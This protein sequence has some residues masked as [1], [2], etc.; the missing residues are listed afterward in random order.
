MAPDSFIHRSQTG[1]LGGT[2]PLRASAGRG[3]GPLT[4]ADE[5][6]ARPPATPEPPPAVA[7]A[8]ATTADLSPAAAFANDLR[9]L[10]LALS[11]LP[12]GTEALEAATAVGLLKPDDPDA[13]SLLKSLLRLAGTPATVANVPGNSLAVDVLR[14]IA[15][16]ESIHQ[17]KGTFTCT[18]ATAQGILAARDPAEYARLVTD[19]AVDGKA[20]TKG[21]DTII[22]DLRGFGT[23]EGRSGTSDL[24]QE[25]FM[26]FGRAGAAESSQGGVFGFA[27]GA[28]NAF[29]GG[30]FGSGS[31]ATAPKAAQSGQPLPPPPPKKPPGRMGSTEAG[32]EKDGLTPAQFSRLMT[33]LTGEASVPLEI[34]ATTDRNALL[35]LIQ[36]SLDRDGP[37]PV[38]VSAED[39][40]THQPTFHAIQLTSFDGQSIFY[41]DPGTG[42][43]GSM[44]LG[45]FFDSLRMLNVPYDTLERVSK[46]GGLGLGSVANVAPRSS[47][48]PREAAWTAKKRFALTLEP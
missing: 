27:N 30:V 42:S 46:D 44:P 16:P 32:A 31:R 2:G 14:D 38:G 33:S 7:K 10:G 47:Q 1:R 13:R 29:T 37:I 34:D 24:L 35:R 15:H 28:L 21:G 18:A 43:K 45:K 26:A 3:T 4:E 17:G 23:D 9:R 11:G 20:T 41:Q 36:E 22:A 19:L 25:A 48:K 40:V 12:G 5:P 8:T 39:P 6:V